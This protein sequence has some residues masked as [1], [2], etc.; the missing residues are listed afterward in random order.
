[1]ISDFATPTRRLYGSA[2]GGW[3]VCKSAPSNTEKSFKDQAVFNGRISSRTGPRRSR[4]TSR[5]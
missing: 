1:M 5:S 4:S 3:L 2:V